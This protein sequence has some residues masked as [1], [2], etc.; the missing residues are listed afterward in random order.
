MVLA[1]LL[2]GYIIMM[3]YDAMTDDVKIC[4]ESYESI[5]YDLKT[6]D[7]EASSHSESPQN[8]NNIYL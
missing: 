1:F 3:S 6:K 8:T 2:L 4:D 5:K 7:L